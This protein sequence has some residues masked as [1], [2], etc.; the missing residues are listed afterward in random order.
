MPDCSYISPSGLQCRE[1]ASHEALC[2]WHA[3]TEKESPDILKELEAKAKKGDSLAGF[4][5]AGLDLS[6]AYL[7]EADLSGADLT[8]ANLSLG[9]LFGINLSGANMFKANLAH[10]NLKE[11][12]LENANLFGA[13]L[14]DVNL[15]RVTWGK[16]N[17]I[18]NHQE[19]DALDKQG[20][21]DQALAKYLEAEEIYRSIRKRYEAAGTSDIAGHFFYNE[22]VTKRKQM[23]PYSFARTWSWFIEVLCGYGEIP[24][25]IIGSSITYILINA[26]IFT[27]MGLSHNNQVHSFDAGQGLIENLKYFG[28]SLYFSIV[29]FTT[30]GYGDFAPVGWARPFAA[31]EAF[32]GAFMIALFILS[33]VKKMTR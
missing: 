2:F 4:Y 27:T 10:A 13:D 1:S 29:T 9:H 8:R 21:A 32:V 20:S 25:R 11:A 19:A 30:L 15:E 24:Y 33:F 5:L 16:D 12:N 6:N 28:Y 14:T 26:L 31:V 22:M 7:M 23:T 3:R 17:R 18:L